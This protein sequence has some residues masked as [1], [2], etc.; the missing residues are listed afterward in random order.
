[1]RLSELQSKHSRRAFLQAAAAVPLIAAQQT[2][3]HL[4][5]P[6]EPRQ[7]LAVTSYPFRAYIESPTNPARDKSKAGMDLKEFPAMIAKRFG[8]HNINPLGD[9]LSSTDATYLKAFRKAVEAADSHVVDL[10][11]SGQDFS[12]PAKSNRDDAVAFGRKWID[13]ATQI[14]SPSIRQH[15]KT[16]AGA[17]PSVGNAAESLARLADYGSQKNIIVNLE[18]DSPVSEDPFF[19]AEVVG[20]VNSPYLR[21]LPDFGN[22]LR[23]HDAAYNQKAVNAMLQYAYN[24]CH[25]KDILRAKS[26]SESYHVDLPQLFADARAKSFRGYFSMEF[27]TG[28][29]DPFE[30]TKNLVK[31]SLKYML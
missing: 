26:G 28:A 1:M 6:S 22:S 24:M 11:L 20:K 12:H 9:H 27:D 14:G 18:N 25:V 2:S 13:I 30:G 5:F 21:T 17:T 16:T 31:Q 15:L 23:G 3:P 10:G 29:G 4:Q 7:R 8:V 19:I